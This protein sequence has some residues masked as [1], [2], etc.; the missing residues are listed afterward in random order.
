MTF[1]FSEL[2]CSCL[3]CEGPMEI[4]FWI[5]NWW[6]VLAIFACYTS[7]QKVFQS[8]IEA[9]GFLGL[10]WLWAGP[11]PPQPNPQQ[12]GCTWRPYTESSESLTSNCLYSKSYKS[13]VTQLQYPRTCLSQVVRVK[14]A[15]TLHLQE[16]M[17]PLFILHYVLVLCLLDLV[18]QPCVDVLAP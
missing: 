4:L 13:S 2:L 5:W 3:R 10:H 17:F 9:S 1:E 18:G 7:T 15:F 12:G 16:I 14:T 11:K 6:Q 8:A